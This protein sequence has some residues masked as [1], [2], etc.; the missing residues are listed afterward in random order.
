MSAN[1]F[2]SDI[3]FQVVSFLN[4]G[5]VGCRR[6]RDKALKTGS[7]PRALSL[8]GLVNLT[9]DDRT[10]LQQ[11]VNV[12]LDAEYDW[13]R[14]S[15]AMLQ[16]FGGGTMKP[17]AEYR[18][19]RMANGTRVIHADRG[20][21]AAQGLMLQLIEDTEFEPWRLAGRCANYAK[22]GR[23]VFHDTKKER[24][25]LCSDACKMAVSR[26]RRQIKIKARKVEHIQAA[27]AEWERGQRE[28]TVRGFV[29][30]EASLRW[31]EDL[32]R[33]E[34]SSI[35]TPGDNKV[36]A[37]YLTQRINDGSITLPK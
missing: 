23:F 16:R 1:K 6:L 36:T 7:N 21:S 9:E 32:Q 33:S 19:T 2:N 25:T 22:C 18:I 37:T 29:L 24:T 35:A 8:V 20:T 14:F 10:E 17:Y 30:R 13:G 26:E 34:W 5:P 4:D 31:R 15:A 3:A 12:W 28:E 11:V 27:I